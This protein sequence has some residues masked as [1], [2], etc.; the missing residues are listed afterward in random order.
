[1]GQNHFSRSRSHA[2]GDLA[3]NHIAAWVSKAYSVPS[4]LGYL[5]SLKTVKKG[6][7]S[8][9]YTHISPGISVPHGEGKAIKLPEDN[10]GDSG[11]VSVLS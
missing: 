9:L 2:P 6:S 4:L 1:M 8:L 3:N 10:M 7:R 5:S 11:I